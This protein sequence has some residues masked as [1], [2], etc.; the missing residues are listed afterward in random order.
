MRNLLLL[1]LFTSIVGQAQ[2][3]PNPGFES[4]FVEIWQEVPE[5]WQTPN[6]QLVPI[7]TKDTDAH[8][9]NYAMKVTAVN[10][11]IGAY[12]WA[13]CLI[14]TSSIPPSLDFY[15]KA[16]AEFGLVS[17]KI[18]FFNGENEFYTE[19]WSSG[20]SINEWTF[21]SLPLSQIEPVMTHA[22]IEVEAFVGDLVPGGAWIS[23]DAMGFDGPLHAS[24][25]QTIAFQVF[26]NPTTSSATLRG[27]LAGSQLS[28]FDLTGKLL[29]KTQLITDI[30]EIDLSDLP[31]GLYFIELI[32]PSGVRASQKLVKK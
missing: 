8:E 14:P 16:L 28:V 24:S 15:V 10:D 18:A 6:G 31:K 25:D 11:G 3:I 20:E 7:V 19:T 21:V 4:W 1:F 12:G 27:E 5:G 23:I 26:P 9:G 2:E 22:E 32:S 13:K 29:E 17:V 30:H